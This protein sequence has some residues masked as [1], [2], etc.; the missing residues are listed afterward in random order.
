MSGAADDGRVAAIPA[1]NAPTWFALMSGMPMPKGSAGYVLDDRGLPLDGIERLTA[2]ALV[3]E[4]VLPQ[5]VDSHR[6]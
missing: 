4:L 1:A 6:P 5:R 2:A 3:A